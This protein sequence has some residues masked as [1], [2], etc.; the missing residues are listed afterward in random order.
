MSWLT[1]R[2]K[3]GRAGGETHVDLMARDTQRIKVDAVT[4]MNVNVGI[5]KEKQTK[6]GEGGSRVLCSVS[7]GTNVLGIAV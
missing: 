5:I 1:V 6:S 7:Y 2:K 3:A 4:E